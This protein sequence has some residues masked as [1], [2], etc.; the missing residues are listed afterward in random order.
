MNL[1]ESIEQKTPSY[2]VIVGALGT[3]VKKPKAILPNLKPRGNHRDS[4]VQK[5]ARSK[6]LQAILGI[7]RAATPAADGLTKSG[8]GGP[9]ITPSSSRD[10]MHLLNLFKSLELS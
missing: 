4:F 3:K 8:P 5:L 1:P 6:V 9:P 10:L 2:R 7:P